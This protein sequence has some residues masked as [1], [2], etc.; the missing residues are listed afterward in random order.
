M[1]FH[2]SIFQA[3]KKESFKT[4]TH[5]TG[6]TEKVLRSGHGRGLAPRWSENLRNDR[7]AMEK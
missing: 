1:P 5:E 6:I 3:S 4:R 2:W 7:V